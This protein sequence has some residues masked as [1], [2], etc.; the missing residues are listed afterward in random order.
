MRALHLYTSMFLVPW[1]MV[2][3]ISAFFLNHNE[4]FTEKLQLR[5][6]WEVLEE[7]DFAPGPAF[8]EES[9]AQAR[10]ILQEL[11]LD[12]AHRIGSDDATLNDAPNTLNTPAARISWNGG[13]A[14][15]KSR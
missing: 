3:A 9:E 12:G 10:A 2:Y 11:D 5:P 8:P 13:C 15:K 14:K 7:T 4:W 1:M 6:D